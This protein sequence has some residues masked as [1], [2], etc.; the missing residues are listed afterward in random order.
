MLD[1]A[2]LAA[3]L[4][5]L[6]SCGDRWDRETPFFLTAACE[7]VGIVSVGL[8]CNFD[9]QCFL[10]RDVPTASPIVFGMGKPEDM[11]ALLW[12]AQVSTVSS[13]NCRH[14]SLAETLGDHLHFGDISEQIGSV[15]A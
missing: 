12:S 4:I 3:S 14:S 9:A 8:K 1:L 2:Q 10:F 15:L 11:I 7:R 6:L 5:A 13:K